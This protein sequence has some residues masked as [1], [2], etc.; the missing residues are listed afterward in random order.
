M[1]RSVINKLLMFIYFIVGALILEAVTFHIL[2]FS[3]MPIYFWYNFVLILFIALLVFTIPNYTAQYVIYTVILF[4]QTIFAYINYSLANIYGDMFSFDMMNLAREAGTAIATSFV[5]FAIILQLLSVFA[6]IA[7]FGGICLK[8]C[9]ADK[10]NVRQHFSIYNLIIL[11]TLECFS[12]GYFIDRRSYF[13]STAEITDETYTQSDSFLMNTQFLKNVSYEKFGTY[14]YFANILIRQIRG[15][16]DE[17]KDAT[18]AY[19]N[20]GNMYDGTYVV[21]GEVKSNGV[22]GIDKDSEGNRNNVIVI[23]MESLEWFGFGDGTYDPNF[24]NLSYELTPNVYSLIYGDD[25]LTD[26][27]NV[28]LNNDAIIAKNFFAKSKTNISEGFGIIGSYPVGETLLSVVENNELTYSMPHILDDLGYTTTYLHSN[29]IDFYDRGATHSKLGFDR[30][31]GKDGVEINGNKVY[32]SEDLKWNHWDNEEDFIKYTMDYLIPTNFQEK[33][34]YSFYLNV[35]SHGPYKYDENDQDCLRYLDYVVYGADDCVLNA[36]GD[37]IVDNSKDAKDLTYTNWYQ[38]VLDSYYD[39]DPALCE[40]LLYY[41]CGVVGLD[42]AIGEIVKQLNEKTYED[43]TKLIDRTTL[44]LYSDHNAYYDKMS[45]RVKDLNPDKF[46]SS[47]LNTIPMILS[48]P[49]IKKYNA[50]Q[51]DNSN[52]FITNNRYSS[53]YDIV[54]TLFDLLGI[55]FN[56]NLYLGNSLFRPSDYVYELNGKTY[57]MRVY[58]SNTGGMFSRDVYTYD[59]AT[60]YNTNYA[61]ERKVEDKEIIDLF[62]AECYNI[63]RKNNYLYIFN[64]YNLYTKL[65]KIYQV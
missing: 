28:N 51:E 12:L 39:N 56:E 10:L 33:P 62:K 37:W 25:Y 26:T 64:H 15:Y 53:A 57:D 36:D 6:M 34:F 16:D 9:R 40:E 54:P 42:A 13:N 41:Q 49:G 63:L 30:V 47:K 60:F 17:F 43:G 22:F 3:G 35:S 14:G 21:D 46:S 58:Y 61:D 50:T 2:N 24:D 59:F 1:I 38:N 45:H 18:M 31:V 48:S 65:E 8:K 27:E 5:Y 23:M 19:F 29:E 4:V 55:K 7:I 11:L 20:A 32:S 44:L 52:K